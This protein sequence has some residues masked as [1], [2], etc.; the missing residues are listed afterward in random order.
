[1]TQSRDVDL[2]L[3]D[4]ASKR[5][6]KPHDWTVSQEAQNS[7]MEIRGNKRLSAEEEAATAGGMRNPRHS[8]ASNPAALVVAGRFMRAI[9]QV[10]ANASVDLSSVSKDVMPKE[11][12][13]AEEHLRSSLCKSLALRS[14][15][16]RCKLRSCGLFQN[17]RPTSTRMYQRGW[18]ARRPS[19]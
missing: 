13:A 12:G 10:R 18:T 14:V 3:N 6:N 2:L 5:S 17:S 15:T 19:G 7:A 8:V 11:F 9:E 16:T 4:I 1:M